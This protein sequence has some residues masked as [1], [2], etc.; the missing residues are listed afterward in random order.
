[1]NKLHVRLLAL[2]CA[3][4]GIATMVYKVNAL[5]LPLHPPGPEDHA[6]VWTVEARVS[7]R[8]Q[9]GIAKVSLTTPFK[10]NGYAVLGEDFVGKRYGLATEHDDNN[11]TVI[12]ARRRAN[13][14]QALYYR[15]QLYPDLTVNAKAHQQPPPPVIPEA[16]PEPETFAIDSLLE[17]VRSLSADTHTFAQQLKLKLHDQNDPNVPV[18]KKLLGSEDWTVLMPK[19]LSRAH[20]PARRVQGLRLVDN[21]HPQELVAWVQVH[22]GKHWIDFTPDGEHTENAP[23]YLVWSY[24]TVDLLQV[25]GGDDAKLKF[26]VARDLRSVVDV[27]ERRASLKNSNLMEF[28][29]F[30]LPVQTQNV[31]RVLLLVPLGAFVVVLMRNLIGIKTFGTFMPVLI[32]LAFRETELL[33]GI[34]LFTLIVSLGLVLRFYLERLKLLLVPRLASVL[35]IVVLLMVVVS[36]GLHKLNLESGISIALFPIVIMA[37]TIERMSL[38][39]EEAGSTEAIKQGASSLSVATVAYLVMNI[40]L[41]AHLAFVFPELLLVVLA[42]NLLMGRYTGYRLMELWRFRHLIRKTP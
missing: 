25:E 5:G 27:A 2:I 28:S 26:S 38:V 29:L 31:Y 16:L 13:G 33:W 42:L 11:Q 4:I 14:K 9:S 36:L 3:T 15:I 12:W 39:W 20:I 35:T 32:A 19:I 30:S 10:P 21:P 22:D 41:L 17:E 24:G 7:F 23:R 1:M 8:A 18:L 6:E 34:T 37:M 40:P